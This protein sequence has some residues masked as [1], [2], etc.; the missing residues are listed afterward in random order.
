MAGI[1]V[2]VKDFGALGE[3]V[4]QMKCG[5]VLPQDASAEDILVLI[6]RILSNGEYEKMCRSMDS[7]QLKSIDTMIDDY[8]LQYEVQLKANMCY[9]EAGMYMQEGG[10]EKFLLLEKDKERDYNN[11]EIWLDKMDYHVGAKMGK[12]FRGLLKI[13]DVLYRI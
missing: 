7:V 5:W 6:K 8:R 12:V 10:I 1:P 13:R 9:Q 3:R 2:V 4:R 11:R